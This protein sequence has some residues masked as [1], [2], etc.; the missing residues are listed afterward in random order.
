MN[1]E[2]MGVKLWKRNDW[3]AT[4]GIVRAT[5]GVFRNNERDVDLIDYDWSLSGVGQP[6]KSY[7]LNC[8]FETD[9]NCTANALNEHVRMYHVYGVRF[10]NCDF[11]DQRSSADYGLRRK[12]IFSMD[13]KYKVLG[14]Y[15]GGTSAT[16]P[17][18]NDSLYN[19]CTFVGLT[20]GVHALNF[21]SMN[22]ITVDQASFTDCEYGVHLQLVDDAMIT[23]NKF[24][25]TEGSDWF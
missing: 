2:G 19:V 13:A 14:T 16:V 15:I 9:T 12:G 24:T 8:L 6:N 22:T 1:V 23:R 17:T 11:I 3:N 10:M 4:G 20:T 7:F 25:R 5:T 18:Y 21:G